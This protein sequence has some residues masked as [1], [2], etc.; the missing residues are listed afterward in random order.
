MNS[1]SPS[2]IQD[3]E[4]LVPIGSKSVEI[5]TSSV[6]D[7]DIYYKLLFGG[8][9]YAVVIGRCTPCWPDFTADNF[10]ACKE[11]LERI[12]E[13]FWA[14]SKSG[15]ITIALLEKRCVLKA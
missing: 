10:F 3:A 14:Y 11:L 6:G 9:L 8:V 4:S 7:F 13:T 12:Q 15:E 1:F 5:G 2:H